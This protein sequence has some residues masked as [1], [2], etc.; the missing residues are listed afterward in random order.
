MN[1]RWNRYWFSSTPQIDLEMARIVIVATQ[2][3]CILFRQNYSLAQFT[4]VLDLPPELYHP[5]PIL[6]LLLSPFDPEYRPSLEVLTAVRTTT[7]VFGIMATIGVLTKTSTALLAVG[8]ILL[9]GHNYSYGDFHHQEAPLVIALMV[10]VFAPIGRAL[11]VDSWLAGRRGAP[12]AAAALDIRSN[13]A[14]W[15]LKL[16]QWQFVLIYLSAIAS[17]LVFRGGIDWLNGFTLQYYFIRNNLRGTGTELGLWLAQ[18]WELIV[19]MEIVILLFQG[20]FV[21]AVL[22]PR[23]RWIYV[24]LGLAFHIGNLVFLHAP[25]PEWMALYAV[26]IP[27]R[28]VF[29]AVGAA[30]KL[31]PVSDPSAA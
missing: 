29:A 8:T 1:E 23:L 17:K 11:A 18:Y 5:L 22:F 14:G 2:V 4:Y 9:I 24:P 6:R 10:L 19:L 3:L 13:F 12:R 15:P 21:L 7:I 26:F 30:S 25:F 16:V 31:K 28:R 20:T 27:W